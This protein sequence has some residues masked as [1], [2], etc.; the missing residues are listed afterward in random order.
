M[1]QMR[2]LVVDDE[3]ELVE[4]LVE[5]LNLRGVEAS[6]ATSGREALGLTP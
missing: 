3:E 2:V 6:G 4:A 1:E 5:R